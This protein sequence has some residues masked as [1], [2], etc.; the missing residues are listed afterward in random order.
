MHGT[1]EKKG[2]MHFPVTNNQNYPQLLFH[3]SAHKTHC[4][5]GKELKTLGKRNL[6]KVVELSFFKI[7]LVLNLLNFIIMVKIYIQKEI[8]KERW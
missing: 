4:I 8:F 3:F 5:C 2:R 6:L 1:L 7:I